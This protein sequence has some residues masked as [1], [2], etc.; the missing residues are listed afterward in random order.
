MSVIVYKGPNSSIFTPEMFFGCS[1][2]PA[3]RDLVCCLMFSECGRRDRG[4]GTGEARQGVDKSDEGR[5]M[6]CQEADKGSGKGWASVEQGTGR[7]WGRA[8]DGLAR[9]E[10]EEGKK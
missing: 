8:G 2:P 10:K 7:D 9:D 3:G 4:Q 6:G 1:P 5:A